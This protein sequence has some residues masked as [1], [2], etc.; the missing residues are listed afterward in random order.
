MGERKNGGDDRELLQLDLHQYGV[1][2]FHGF[3][4]PFVEK[5]K[6]FFYRFLGFAGWGFDKKDTNS[7][8]VKNHAEIV[9]DVRVCSF[10]SLSW[11]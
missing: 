11:L 6:L 1:C 10:G 2:S 4:L 3:Y 7:Q 8:T 5:P 9:K